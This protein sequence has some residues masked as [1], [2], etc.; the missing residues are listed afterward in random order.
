MAEEIDEFLPIK[1]TTE[2]AKKVFKHVVRL[3]MDNMHR[4]N[5]DLTD[6]VINL[7]RDTIK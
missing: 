6:E 4:E 7:I 1:E 5:P 3:E 2:E